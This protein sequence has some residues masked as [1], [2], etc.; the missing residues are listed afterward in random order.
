MRSD[1]ILY[2]LQHPEKIRV[3]EMEDLQKVPAKNSEKN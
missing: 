1:R 2:L 3:M